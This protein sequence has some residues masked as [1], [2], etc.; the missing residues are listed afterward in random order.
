MVFHY[1]YL[2]VNIIYGHLLD[3]VEFFLP[4]LKVSLKELLKALLESVIQKYEVDYLHKL[5]ILH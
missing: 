4:S 1:C 2:L 3:L 5:G